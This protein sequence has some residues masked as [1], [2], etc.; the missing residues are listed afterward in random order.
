MELAN[1]FGH[2]S[3]GLMHLGE[4]VW[5]III[6]YILMW[7]P[8]CRRINL[9]KYIRP[10]NFKHISIEPTIFELNT[11]VS[12]E[13]ANIFGPINWGLMHLGVY[14]WPNIVVCILIRPRICPPNNLTKYIRPHN[15]NHISIESTI[16]ELNIY[17]SMELAN[18]FGHINWGQM[19]LRDY[20][21][22]NVV[23]YIL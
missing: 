16:F 10:Y 18:V 7:P 22:P 21:W 6:G 23:G 9:A 19:Y 5:P 1:V 2:I 17:L 14:V 8:I 15:F 13:L 11:C 20:V 4:Y 12:M 3:W